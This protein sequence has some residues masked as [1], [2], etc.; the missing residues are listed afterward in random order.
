MMS[1]VAV[2]RGAF[3]KGSTHDATASPSWRGED[4]IVGR[5]PAFST[6]HI[7]ER[8]DSTA[9]HGSEVRA[10]LSA[11]GGRMTHL[12]LQP[13]QVSAAAVHTG[14][15]ELWLVLSGAGRL[16]RRHGSDESITELE[17]G[18]AVDLPV[19]TRFQFRCDGSEP[20][21]IVSFTIPLA[22][23]EGALTLT[24]GMWD[25]PMTG[26]VATHTGQHA[27]RRRDRRG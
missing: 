18:T 5:V 16:W 25:S 4:D 7:P 12:T 14:V 3:S 24:N 15:T 21:R 26:P 9:P 6:R 13:G 22:T 27:S 17:Q 23:A 1:E 11:E 20:L 2:R 8:Q 19:G 10:L